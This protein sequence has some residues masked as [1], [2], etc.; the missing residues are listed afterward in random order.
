MSLLSWER[1]LKYITT[2]SGATIEVSLLSWE[3]GLKYKVYI[4]NSDKELVAPIV[5][6]WIEISQKILNMPQHQSLLSW[7]RGLKFNFCIN[8][9]YC[10]QSLLSW[11]R[12]LK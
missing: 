1:G 9:E 5:G 12:G 8:E 2:A 6:A 4:Y 3:R 10:D 7:E 11:E